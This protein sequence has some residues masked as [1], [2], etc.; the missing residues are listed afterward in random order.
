MAFGKTKEKKPNRLGF[1]KFMAWKASDVSSAACFVIVNSY[2]SLFCTNY[3]GMNPATVG[4]IL[5]LSNIVDA[6]TDLICCY[7][8][9]NSK[10]TKWGK[11]RPYELG[12]IGMWICTILVFHTPSGWSNMLK[13]IWVFFM[14]TFAFGVFNTFRTAAQQPYMIRAFSANRTVIGKL[15]SYGGFVTMLGSMVVS[16]TFPVLMGRIATSAEGWR[17]ILLIYGL[18]M[19]LL[20]LPRFLFVKE[21]PAIDAGLQHDKVSLKTIL[22]MITT[23][24]YAWL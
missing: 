15:G 7:V 10:I 6:I 19:L 8:V 4:T 13:N 22:K 23:N 9:D 2:L 14:Y 18:P 21:D 20:G 16:M 12:I 11:M 3:L 17:Q 5:L 1:G 24:R